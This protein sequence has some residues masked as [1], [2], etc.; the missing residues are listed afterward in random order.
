MDLR[1]FGDSLYDS[2][3]SHLSRKKHVFCEYRVKIRQFFL[4]FSFSLASRAYLF[5]FSTSPS[6]KL[7]FSLQKPPSFSTIFTPNQRKG[8][9]FH[10]FT[11]YFKFE[12][13]YFMDLL[14][15]LRYWYL[16]NI[17]YHLLYLLHRVL[18]CHEAYY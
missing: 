4:N 12:A 15:I 14:L 6:L 17:F 9:D 7:P 16:Y 11:L 3:A 18:L 10:F 5:I 2:L 13:L 8:M 1:V